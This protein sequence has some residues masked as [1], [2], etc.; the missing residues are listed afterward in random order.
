MELIEKQ[1]TEA[2]KRMKNN[3]LIRE[4]LYEK[5]RPTGSLIPRLYGLPKIHK[6]ALPLRP[7]LDMSGSPYHSVAGWLAE[8]IE[9]V[10]E[11]LSNHSLRDTFQFVECIQDIN[12]SNKHMLSL[13]VESLFTNVPLTE[14]IC[15]IC[16]YIEDNKLNIGIPTTDLKELLLRCTLNVQFTFNE[17]IY[18]Q[19]N[20]TAMGSPLGP[21]LADCFTSSLQN[22]QLKSIIQSFQTYKRYADD[23]FIICNSDCNLNNILDVF[24]GCRPAI[25][26]TLEM[27]NESSIHFLDVNLS[28]R[29]D[30]T[31]KRSIYRKLS[32]NGQ[33]TNFYSW[34]PIGRKRN[35]VRSL[36]TRIRRICSPD[37][38]EDEL[39]VLKKILIE[40]GFPPRFIDKNIHSN[41][42]KRDSSSIPKKILYMSL[43]FKGDLASEIMKKTFPAAS[44]RIAFTSLPLLF[45][46]L[47]KKIPLLTN[48]VCV[49][50]F[51]CS[52]GAGYIGR[53]TAVL[54]KRVQEH[55]PAWL[56][57]GGSEAIRSAI[58]EHLVDN[59]HPISIASTFKVKGKE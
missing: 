9:P 34:V 16:K 20:G 40:N 11:Q 44:L 26:F 22:D 41:P 57:K 30:G 36:A 50:Q 46:N 54:S 27:E 1:L 28:K 31:L 32:W 52:C 43:E 15:F 10:R 56:R 53:S 7:I 2:L 4:E 14:T 19:K 21:L 33:Q 58:I 13:D 17:A 49:Y 5:I 47:K 48:S 35:L 37:T 55:Y 59:D 39:Y 42:K 12:A 38:V 23:T 45:N 51:T 6:A 3:H 8:I 18:R 29:T 25:K 24:N